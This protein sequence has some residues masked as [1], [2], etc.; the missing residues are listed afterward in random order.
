[1]WINQAI[2]IA[3]NLRDTRN[4]T[5]EQLEDSE[6]YLFNVALP[7]HILGI[8]CNQDWK[9]LPKILLNKYQYSPEEAQKILEEVMS[10]QWD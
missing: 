3:T 5:S 4:L 1:M 2:F 8:N 7:K 9:E 10:Q 6:P